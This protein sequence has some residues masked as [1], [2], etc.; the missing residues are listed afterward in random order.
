MKSVQIQALNQPLS[1]VELDK[2]TAS[3]HEVIVAI[4][5]AAL[6]HRD[7]F[8]QQGKYPG[9]TL[10]VVLGSDGSGVV[11]EVGD[12]VS[13]DWIGQEV[14]INPSID[15]GDDERFYG[16]NFKIL[17]MPMNGTFSEFLKIDV[18]NIATKPTHL[19]F[20]EAAALP[21]AGLTGWR[22]LVS[23]AK[24][25][26]GERVLITGIGGGVALFVLQFAVAMGAEV[27]VT[28][29][30]DDKI[31]KAIAIGAK[32]GI[33]YQDA[34]WHK[35][36]LATAG[37]DRSGYFEVIIDSAGGPNFAK[38]IDV[39]TAGGRICF[40]GGTTGNIT[41]IIPAKVFFKQLS[42]LG[43]TMGSSVEFADMLTFIGDHQIKPIIDSVR[44][45]QEAE[46]AF[47][48]M[49]AGHQFGK[50]VLKVS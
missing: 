16:K 7:V 19:S 41:D 43:T 47:R 29:G 45:I 14:V 26:R 36:L 40:F 9:I 2:P 50:I 22:A 32:G 48:H 12:E 28:S 18:R 20:E 6:N 11:V 39:A 3:A 37:A 44:P 49:D 23:R 35:N 46:A 1:I 13:Q 8:I 15:W 31:E 38:L 10:P 34:N 30:S 24:I 27:W 4:K 5:A 33:N 21:L 17:G 25:Q 42:I